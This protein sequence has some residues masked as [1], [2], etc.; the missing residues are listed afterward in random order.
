MFDV[1]RSH[2][3]LRFNEKGRRTAGIHANTVCHHKESIVT[4]Y[5][6]FQVLSGK[7]SHSKLIHF[8]VFPHYINVE[9]VYQR[10]YTLMSLS[11]EIMD[12]H[13]QGIKLKQTI[14]C[15]FGAVST[16]I[17]RELYS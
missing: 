1:R 13:N 11:W 12:D 17:L 3:A 6:S 8:L 5:H 9:N 2:T 7:F 15:T 10:P 4:D 16:R 14:S